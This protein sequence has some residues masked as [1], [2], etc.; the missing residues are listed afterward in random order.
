MAPRPGY[1]YLAVTCDKS[2]GTTHLYVRKYSAG[3]WNPWADLGTAG[4]GLHLAS[5]PAITS[6]G[7]N[8]FAQVRGDIFVRRSDGQLVHT[9][10][11]NGADWTAFDLPGGVGGLVLTGDPDAASWGPNT[12]FVTSTDIYGKIQFLYY[13]GS[14]WYWDSPGIAGNG[15]AP[16]GYSMRPSPSIT[17]LGD[18][19]LWVSAVD[20]TGGIWNLA[21][22]FGW[23][24]WSRAATGSAPAGIESTAW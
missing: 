21:Y 24:T 5:G 14:G 1:L 4:G 2:D 23:G 20:T 7:S 17:A 16:V 19:R 12:L 6:W 15:G 9:S 8:S 13:N 18:N 22:N 11:T 3:S 10:M